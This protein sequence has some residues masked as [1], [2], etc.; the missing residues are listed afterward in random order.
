MWRRLLVLTGIAALAAWFLRRRP[1]ERPPAVGPDPSEELR[2]R[3]DE[4]RLREESVQS[5]EAPVVE[6]EVPK[7]PADLDAM[8]R[9]VHDRARAAVDEMQGPTE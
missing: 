5:A 4:A 1:E 6:T 7:E 9:D 2:R 3:L 8:R